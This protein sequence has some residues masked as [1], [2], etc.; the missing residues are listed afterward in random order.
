MKNRLTPGEMIERASERLQLPGE[1]I[2]GMPLVTITGTRR[3]HI[4]N[5]R[6]IV[7]YSDDEIVVGISKGRIRI[8]GAVLSLAAMTSD[9]MLISGNVIAV[10][11]EG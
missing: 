4:E 6:G 9:E 7:E 11:F 2:A 3:V 10:E 5:H 1:I 8:R